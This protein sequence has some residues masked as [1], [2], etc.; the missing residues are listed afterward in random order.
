MRNGPTGGGPD[1]VKLFHTIFAG[2]DPVGVDAQGADLMGISPESIEYIKLG[3]SAGLGSMNLSGGR[4]IRDRKI[5][6]TPD[7]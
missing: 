7:K 4:I 2:V 1:D 6:N 3:D 5:E